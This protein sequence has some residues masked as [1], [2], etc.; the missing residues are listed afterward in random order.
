ME[1]KVGIYAPW[2]IYFHKMD[3]LFQNDPE[4]H[5]SFRWIEASDDVKNGGIGNIT[6][7]VDNPK[8]AEALDKL[9]PRTKILGNVILEIRVV[10]ANLT[11]NDGAKYVEA[12]FQG[13]GAFDHFHTVHVTDAYMSNEI[14][15]CVFKKEVVQYPADDLGSESGMESTLYE[16]LAREIIGDIGGVYFCTDI[17]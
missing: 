12:A 16:D 4:V 8:K 14:S 7:R 11:V 6:L 1:K 15:Y 10:P 5:L 9:L 3:A 13:N 2:V 17:K